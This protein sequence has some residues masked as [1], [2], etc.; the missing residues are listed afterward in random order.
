M[1]QDNWQ[2]RVD[3][4]RLTWS[5]EREPFWATQGSAQRGIANLLNEAGEGGWELVSLVP[6]GAEPQSQ[7]V[8]VLH[9]TFKR[10]LRGH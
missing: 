7:R 8:N 10:P 4:Y 6:G 3:E 2:Y 5:G 9:A 1:A